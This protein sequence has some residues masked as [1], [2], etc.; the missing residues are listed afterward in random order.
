MNKVIVVARRCRVDYTT[1]FVFFFCFWN[2]SH[3]VATA[4]NKLQSNITVA[5]AGRHEHAFSFKV[6]YIDFSLV[7]MKK[8]YLQLEVCRAAADHPIMVDRRIHKGGACEP[9]RNFF[10]TFLHWCLLS[11]YRRLEVT[12]MKSR[13][14]ILIICHQKE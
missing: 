2:R 8:N 13:R 11:S 1:F 6:R 7:R 5:E 9:E 10:I 4:C 3:G 14:D 12:R